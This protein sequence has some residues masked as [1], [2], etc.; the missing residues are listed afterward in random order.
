[1]NVDRW[2]QSVL[3]RF[4]REHTFGTMQQTLGWTASKIR[5][6]DNADL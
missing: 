2:C 6:V 4:D 3:R 5:H 1:M